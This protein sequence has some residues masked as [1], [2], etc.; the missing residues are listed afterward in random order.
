MSEFGED[1]EHYGISGAFLSFFLSI[2]LLS[3]EGAEVLDIS[4]VSL[5]FLSSPLSIGVEC[6]HSLRAGVF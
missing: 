3:V 4:D 5:S 6:A 1:Y 2:F